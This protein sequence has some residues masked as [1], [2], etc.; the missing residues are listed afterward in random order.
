MRTQDSECQ[1]PYV[2]ANPKAVSSIKFV[3]VIWVPAF[4]FLFRRV[5]MSEGQGGACDEASWPS[6]EEGAPEEEGPSP[7]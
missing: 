4:L 7:G 1:V 6:L 5:A 3:P 2:R